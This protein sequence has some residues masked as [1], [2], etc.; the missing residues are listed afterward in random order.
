MITAI[1]SLAAV[2]TAPT[3]IQVTETVQLHLAST[4]IMGVARQSLQTVRLRTEALPGQAAGKGP[5]RAVISTEDKYIV[6]YTEANK[7]TVKMYDAEGKMTSQ[8]TFDEDDANHMMGIVLGDPAMTNDE[9]FGMSKTVEQRWLD[10][11]KDVMGV[12]CRLRYTRN[13]Q[14]P[15]KAI[16]QTE[17]TE[18]EDFSWIPVDKQ[19]KDSTDSG[20]LE[21]TSYSIDGSEH[22]LLNYRRTLSEKTSREPMPKNWPNITDDQYCRTTTSK[23]AG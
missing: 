9:F 18:T 15:I 8:Q 20:V 7:V 3:E 5:T 1:L 16:G 10:E 13:S 2:M 23:T 14:N 19:T 22:K 11:Y 4:T 17:D 12:K 6:M 21:W